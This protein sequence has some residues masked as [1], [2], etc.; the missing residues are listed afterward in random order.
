[1]TELSDDRSQVAAGG[2]EK[3]GNGE[4][5]HTR[6]GGFGDCGEGEVECFEFLLLILRQQLERRHTRLVEWP[7]EEERHKST[8]AGSLHQKFRKWRELHRPHSPLPLPSPPLPLPSASPLTTHTLPLPLPLP[9]PPTPPTP[10]CL[11]PHHPHPPAPSASPSPPT[12]S[13]SPLPLPHHP[14]PPTPLCLSLTTHTLPL[15]SASPSPPTPSH[16]PHPTRCG[17]CSWL[18]IQST[19]NA[20]HACL[21]PS[22]YIYACAASSPFLAANV[23]PDLTDILRIAFPCFR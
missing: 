5:E 8:E 16:S 4:D 14:H 11:S 12:P 10:L 21:H 20:R 6:E 18:F 9:S 17:V 1:M 23:L 19:C 22:L 15:P 7:E 3:R 13:H 2:M